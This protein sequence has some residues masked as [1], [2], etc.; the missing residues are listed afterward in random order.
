MQTQKRLK[1]CL[2]ELRTRAY[3]KFASESP[4]VLVS[5]TFNSGASTY[6][7]WHSSPYLNISSSSA[8]PCLLSPSRNLRKIKKSYC[9]ERCLQLPCG[10]SQRL[11]PSLSFFLENYPPTKLYV[12]SACASAQKQKPFTKVDSCLFSLRTRA[13]LQKHHNQPCSGTTCTPNVNACILDFLRCYKHPLLF[14]FLSLSPPQS[15]YL[16]NRDRVY[17]MEYDFSK[18]LSRHCD[19]SVL[20]SLFLE[21]YSR[22]S[23]MSSPR[24]IV[25]SKTWCTP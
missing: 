20:L 22:Q 23:F 5:E 18:R 11:S 12:F 14:S 19:V 8:L 4:H 2:F 7:S 16:Q 17:G 9:K 25:K 10:N 13:D 24:E 3:Q 6:M 1:T 15:L 21:R